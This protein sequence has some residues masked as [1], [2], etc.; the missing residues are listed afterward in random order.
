MRKNLF[1]Y[2]FGVLC[3]LALFTACS[4]DD[5]NKGGNGGDGGNKPVSLQEAVVGTYDGDLTVEM[6]GVSLT[7][8]PLA[9][10]IFMKAD[11]TDK[12][13]LVLRNFSIVVGT[14]EVPVGDILVPGVA[15]S[16]DAS[17]VELAET[18][19]T[20]QHELLGELPITVKGNVISG[21]A[22]LAIDVIWTSE[23]TQ[24]PI[25][26]AY[27]GDR[28]ASEILDEDYAKQI[29]LWYART[30]L[31]AT[32]L[33]ENFE[34]KYPTDGIAFEYIGHNKVRIPKFYLSFP[35]EKADTRDIAVDEVLIE[36]SVEG[37]IVLKEVTKKIESAQ[38]GDVDMVLSGIIKDNVLTLNIALK[39]ETCDAKYVFVGGEQKT[40]NSIESMTLEGEGI[41]VQPELSDKEGTFYVA[42]GSANRIFVPT[43]QLSEEA[44]VQYNGADF[45]AGIAIDFTE[46]QSFDV[47]SQKGTKK[48]YKII[49]KEWVEASFAHDMN[50]WELKNETSSEANKYQEY[51]EPKG[52]ATSNEGLKWI[53]LMY[54]ELYSKEA[55]YL[56]TNVDGVAR[57][58]TMDTKG[59]Y[60]FITSVPKVTSGSVYNGVFKVDI[61]NTL[62]STHFGEPCLK[63]PKSFTGKYKYQA[64]KTYYEAKYPGD[65]KKA[66]EVEENPSKTDAPAMNAVLYEV[67][68][69]TYEYLDGTNLL[70]SDK[71]A[72]IASVK[73]AADQADYVDFN[74]NFEWKEGKSWDATKKYK[75]AIVCS[76]SK[77]GDK[78]S[79]APGSVLYVDNLKIGF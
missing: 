8:D 64:G 29:G 77:D 18:T 57:L 50:E 11:A 15:L 73:D 16:G 1:V 44:K 4:D 40:G 25:S 67:D 14:G 53:K 66:H 76:S 60:V 32:G 70:T 6:N 3:S 23:G 19:I 24:M 30:E 12:I 37:D 31:T 5:D 34:L 21:K 78:F 41:F 74:V 33:P 68:T 75:L 79:G 51:Y 22:D 7:P 27:T 26:V 20:M 56:V 54:D 10:R 38:K 48:T 9:Q 28:V 71:I 62:K 35:G 63:E 47:L 2:L 58:E 52:W 39:D 43:F 55:P 42:T 69:Y 45:V 61:T 49:A 13:E 59:K 17:N 65:P 46:P 72:A 36:K